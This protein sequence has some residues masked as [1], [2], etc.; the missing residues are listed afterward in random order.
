[1]DAEGKSYLTTKVQLDPTTAMPLQIYLARDMD[2]VLAV[3]FTAVR[4]NVALVFLSI[5]VFGTVAVYAVKLRVEVRAREQ[6][7]AE[8]IEARDV[9]E[10]A[11]RAKSTFLAT[12]SHEIR[13]PMN[14][15]MSMAELLSLTRLD[16]E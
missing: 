10:A 2:A 11:T 9:A 1:M 3:A 14:G 6:A 12:M 13:T 8:L 5:V 15:V 16:A 7:E 4:R